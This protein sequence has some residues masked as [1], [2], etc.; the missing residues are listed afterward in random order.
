MATKEFKFD[1]QDKVTITQSGR[2]GFVEALNVDS[3]GSVSVRVRYTD[4]NNLLAYAWVKES[5][6]EAAAA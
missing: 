6:L 3:Y 1:L 5:D 2:E 4:T